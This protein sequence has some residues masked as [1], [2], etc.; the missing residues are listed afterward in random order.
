MDLAKHAKLYGRM[1]RAVAEAAP[2]RVS[3]LDGILKTYDG[4]P[5]LL[6]RFL[7]LFDDDPWK[8][9]ANAHLRQAIFR[10]P[11]EVRQEK[12]IH[13]I[14]ESGHKL[15]DQIFV[16]THEYDPT[17]VW[18][19]GSQALTKIME[20]FGT[21]EQKEALTPEGQERIKKKKKI[22]AREVTGDIVRTLEEVLQDPSRIVD[23]QSRLDRQKVHAI[24]GLDE[25]LKERMLML[26]KVVYGETAFVDQES[27]S[28]LLAADP[29]GTFFGWYKRQLDS[30]PPAIR[31]IFTTINSPHIEIPDS[32]R[33]FMLGSLIA[34]AAANMPIRRESV[35][36]G[37]QKD[38]DFLVKLSVDHEIIAKHGKPDL[39]SIRSILAQPE[40]TLIDATRVFDAYPIDEVRREVNKEYLSQFKDEFEAALKELESV[41]IIDGKW[42]EDSYGASIP[43]GRLKK[44]VY[45]AT[46]TREDFEA[47]RNMLR[48]R[49]LTPS[50]DG[51]YK[52]LAMQEFKKLADNVV[53]SARKL[54]YMDKQ[55]QESEVKVEDPKNAEEIVNR[56]KGTLYRGSQYDLVENFALQNGITIDEFIKRVEATRYK[57]DDFWKTKEWTIKGHNEARLYSTKTFESENAQQFVEKIKQLTP[58]EEIDDRLKTAHI[59]VKNRLV[60]GF[61][62][63]LLDREIP[64][65]EPAMVETIDGIL[66]AGEEIDRISSEHGAKIGSVLTRREQYRDVIFYE[67]SVNGKVTIRTKGY[68]D[69]NEPYTEIGHVQILDPLKLE[70]HLKALGENYRRAEDLLDE[71]LE[72]ARYAVSRDAEPLLARVELDTSDKLT[73]RNM[74]NIK[75]EDHVE[76]NLINRIEDLYQRL[77][78]AFTFA[79]D[80]IAEGSEEFGKGELF[81]RYHVTIKGTT[82]KDKGRFKPAFD[83]FKW[84]RKLGVWKAFRELTK[85]QVGDITERVGEYNTNYGTGLRVVIGKN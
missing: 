3:E 72:K 2:E 10:T 17:R 27:K 37:Y 23:V 19:S 43:M 41:F 6:G 81:D 33:N 69:T 15:T 39:V 62:R 71:W 68:E 64:Y 40:I 60:K 61:N 48:I 82:P 75:P 30:L 25:E 16:L 24:L 9:A 80:V 13:G 66:A 55:F 14:S 46:L 31:D 18:K 21:Y 47:V 36:G 29:G 84:N 1:N 78:D 70:S 7:D 58:Y 79:P 52:A 32:E 12:G 65:V 56:W 38:L 76:Q 50:E 22:Q 74:Q 63:Y 20:A 59:I 57:E 77:N 49:T 5:R 11:Q 51:I 8:A 44:S 26:D 34:Y 42:R 28:Y 4:D 85:G 35:I 83:E 67:G 53:I 45:A 54:K 73:W